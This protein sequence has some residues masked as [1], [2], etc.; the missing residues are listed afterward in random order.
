M[1]HPSKGPDD[2]VI[3]VMRVLADYQDGESLDAALA[4]VGWTPERAKALERVVEAFRVCGDAY[5]GYVCHLAARHSGL[6]QSTEGASWRSATAAGPAERFDHERQA[7][8]ADAVRRVREEMLEVFDAHFPRADGGPLTFA[9]RPARGR[10]FIVR[11]LY[12]TDRA[13]D[14]SCCKHC[15]LDW[16]AP[17]HGDITP[18]E[19]A[20][21]PSR[22]RED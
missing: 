20:D 7:G 4:R 5:A 9:E 10:C 17:V 22:P 12:E 11:H 18:G 3:A 8:R 21:A 16:R 2:A 14:R 19:Q 6:H 1:M 13:G 15:G